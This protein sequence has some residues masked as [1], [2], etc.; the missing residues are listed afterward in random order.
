VKFFVE[1]ILPTPSARVATPD[2]MIV[3]WVDVFNK[4]GKLFAIFG[5]IEHGGVLL[6]YCSPST[7]SDMRSPL[8]IM[9]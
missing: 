2:A 4:G 8:T 5:S 9:S 1:L 3:G 7:K 6:L